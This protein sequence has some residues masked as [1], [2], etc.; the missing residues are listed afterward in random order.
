MNLLESEKPILSLFRENLTH[1][2]VTD[3]FV[4]L[5]GSKETAL[6]ILYHAEKRNLSL[7]LVFSLVWVE[8]RFDRRAVNQNATSIDRGLFQ[9]NSRTFRELSLEDF[10]NPEINARYGTEYLVYCFNQS[11]E[12]RIAVAIYN[13]GRTRV[14]QGRTPASTQIYVERIMQYRERLEQEFYRYIRRS[15]PAPV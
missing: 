14:V 8:S 12:D 1:A 2:A 4:R 15:F 11:P 6:P 13:A 9:L 5:A 10:F 7:S 3:F